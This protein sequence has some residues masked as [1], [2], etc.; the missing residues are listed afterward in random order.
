MP[1]MM[2]E[3]LIDDC[4]GVRK[5]E[6]RNDWQ[7]GVRTK[8]GITWVATCLRKSDAIAIAKRWEE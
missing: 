7:W 2:V 1:K 8:K 3:K 4:W 5:M 6:K